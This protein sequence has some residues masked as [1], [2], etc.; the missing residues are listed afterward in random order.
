MMPDFWF[1]YYN[2]GTNSPI[3]RNIST[4]WLCETKEFLIK[5]TIFFEIPNRY[6]RDLILKENRCE[7]FFEIFS[8]FENEIHSPLEKYG[9]QIYWN[10]IH[11]VIIEICVDN[12]FSNFIIGLSGTIMTNYSELFQRYYHAFTSRSKRQI[13]EQSASRPNFD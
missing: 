12:N 8:V 7:Y 2:Q 6:D 9:F 11:L 1:D 3:A 5:T 10:L 13:R 4:P